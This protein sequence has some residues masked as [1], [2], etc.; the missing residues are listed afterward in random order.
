MRRGVDI[1]GAAKRWNQRVWYPDGLPL[2]HQLHARGLSHLPQPFHRHHPGGSVTGHLAARDQ[3][4]RGY[5][6]WIHQELVQ[7]RPQG[8]RND[9][10]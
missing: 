4:V 5:Q 6:S 7:V 8:Q 9:Q 3:S 2:L 10:N 1:R